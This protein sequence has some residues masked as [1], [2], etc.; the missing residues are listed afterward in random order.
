MIVGPWASQGGIRC[1]C[2]VEIF[3]RLLQLLLLKIR[4]HFHLQYCRF[5]VAVVVEHS[6]LFFVEIRYSDR[7]DFAFFHLLF[8]HL[9]WTE[10][11]RLRY[12]VL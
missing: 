11:F 7:F 3:A 4:V 2:Y 12:L 9:E 1:H 8:H 10:S 6:Q 5:D